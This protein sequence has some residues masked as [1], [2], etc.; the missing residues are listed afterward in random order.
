MLASPKSYVSLYASMA[1]QLKNDTMKNH[2]K[3]ILLL[4]F[5]FFST[6]NYAQFKIPPK[7]QK[8]V[9]AYPDFIQSANENELIWKDGTVIQYDD[10]KNKTFNELLND[11][12]IEDMMFQDYTMGA[13]WS[14]PPDVN[15]EPGRIR[16]EPLFLKMYGS[17]AKE[18]E[19]N[20]APVSWLPKSGGGTVYITSVN[21]ADKQLKKVSDELD[22]LPAEYKKYILNTAGTFYW[23]VIKNTNRLSM[24]SFGIAIDINTSYSNYWEWEKNIKYKN[25][26][27]IEIVEIFEKYGYIWGGKWYHYD[28]MHFEYRP[29]LLN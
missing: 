13:N 15:F 10:G 17:S 4:L 20:L 12:D 18:V 23:R 29:E 1:F 21:G 22:E 6:T 3:L 14:S 25:K 2:T 5:L 8:L 9:N 19:R 24:H 28:T 27:P 11:P 7:L 16:Y 26:I